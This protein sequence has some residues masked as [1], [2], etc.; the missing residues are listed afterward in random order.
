[1]GEFV[2]MSVSSRQLTIALNLSIQNKNSKE[3]HSLFCNAPKNKIT[4]K[5]FEADPVIF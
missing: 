1:M 5:T 3:K 2:G 4:A